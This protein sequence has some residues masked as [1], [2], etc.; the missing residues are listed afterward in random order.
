MTQKY[1]LLEEF[2]EEAHPDWQ[3]QLAKGCGTDEDDMF[4][5]PKGSE[6]KRTH[7]L[8]MQNALYPHWSEFAMFDAP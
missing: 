4:V 5:F 2:T 7:M 3:S 6:N 1:V 8:L